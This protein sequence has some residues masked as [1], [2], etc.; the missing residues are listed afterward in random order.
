MAAAAAVT[1]VKPSRLSAGGRE[2]ATTRDSD[3]ARSDEL[4][5]D[6]QVGPVS[7]ELIDAARLT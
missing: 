5:D 7:Q 6:V 1:A 2:S 4:D 3:V